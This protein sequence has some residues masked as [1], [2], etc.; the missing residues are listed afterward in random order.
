MARDFHS[1]YGPERRV[2]RSSARSGGG[3]TSNKHVSVGVRAGQRT[4]NKVGEGAAARI[5]GQHVLMK[6]HPPLQQPR[7][8]AVPLGN[9][10]ALNVNGGGPG[11]GREVFDC[12]S[13][14]KH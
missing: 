2:E 8:A 5:G 11:K 12:G 10:V 3:I 7:Q 4:T 9:E 1:M 6:E 13:Q 14:G